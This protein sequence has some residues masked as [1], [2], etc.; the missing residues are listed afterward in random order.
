MKVGDS[1]PKLRRFGGFRDRTLNQVFRAQTLAQSA[2]YLNFIIPA[3]GI[4]FTLFLI[5]D[6]KLLGDNPLFAQALVCRLSFLALTLTVSVLQLFE[7]YAKYREA[8]IIAVCIGGVT[9][10]GWTFFIYADADPLVQSMSVMV[11]IAAIFLLPLRITYAVLFSSAIA[12]TGL[13]S[14]FIKGSSSKATETASFALYFTLMVVFSAM[15]AW[16]TERARRLEFLRAEEL[17]ELSRIDG[18]TGILNR[19]AGEERLRSNAEEIGRYGGD[20]AAIIFDI[21]FFKKV[22][23]TLGHAVG[24]RVLKELCDRSTRV[25]R[26]SD[27]LARWGGEEF[28]VIMPRSNMS[29][30]IGLAERLRALFEAEPIEGVG[31]VTA[32][33][34]VTAL[35]RG[36][37]PESIIA[38]ADRALYR[39]KENGRNRVT[40]D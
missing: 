20:A 39:S 34:G 9:A 7:K 1:V 17:K 24:D 27:A 4:V 38:R 23:D 12:I 14:V 26:H 36:D 10:Y 33:F 28:I 11:M 25:L 8:F 37:S 32:S 40:E 19:R 29:A 2:P 22:N 18:L 16:R 31:V 5:P 15:A 3:L 21:D 6:R 30:A 13:I 35:R